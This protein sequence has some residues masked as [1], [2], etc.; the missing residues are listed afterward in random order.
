MWGSYSML[1]KEAV[2]SGRRLSG[3]ELTALFT[4]FIAATYGF[5]IYLFSTL[6][7]DMKG[8]LGLDYGDAGTV[9][10]LAQVGFMVA[11]LS[12]GL[13]AHRFGAA[14]VVLFSVLVCGVCLL[15]LSFA[16]AGWQ[17]VGLLFLTGAAA[18]SVWVP[19]VSLAQAALPTTHQGKAL[20]LM[21][22][23][24]AYGVF[25]N[26][27]AVP[28][29]VPS[30]GW[31]SVWL[32]MGVVTLILFAWGVVRLSGVRFESRRTA[33]DT[34]P[35]ATAG[36]LSVLRS[37][38]SA[39][40]LAMMFFNGIAC[41]P[42]QN[43]LVSLLR[44][45]LGYG[46]AEASRAWS[47]IGFIGMFGGLLMGWVADR[48]TVL[49]AMLLTYALLVAA[50]MAFLHHSSLVEI[51]IGAAL[52]GLAFNAIFGLMPAFV[53][54]NFHGRSATTIFGF[55][56]VLLGLGSMAGNYLGGATKDALGSFQLI[57]LIS[58]GAGIVLLGLTVVLG[59]RTA[60]K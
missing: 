43:Y 22:S 50:I 16:T 3:L 25:L 52:F 48:I 39:I 12:S 47:A 34:E 9:I 8:D 14:R 54:L 29:L 26:G 51:Y 4:G 2:L 20:G 41:M 36:T 10:A 44:D 23:G 40:V 33:V 55:G 7:P 46:V 11:A 5:G 15:A 27:L 28:A 13:L 49:R 17:L 45:D 31:Q 35:G 24:T 42:T 32:V 6:I 37:P 53:S 59:I 56:N 60:E 58:L 30:Y 1:N 18:A 57:Y 21:S 38:L 19:M